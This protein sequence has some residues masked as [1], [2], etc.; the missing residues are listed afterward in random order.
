ME[1]FEQV[2]GQ[3]SIN[4]T[5]S[6]QFSLYALFRNIWPWGAWAWW[7]IFP[8]NVVFL[9]QFGAAAANFVAINSLDMEIF[10]F[11]D[12]GHAVDICAV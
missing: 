3:W 1:P 11:I 5:R 10:C 7:G 4:D 12:V 2:L 8:D 9:S 6:S